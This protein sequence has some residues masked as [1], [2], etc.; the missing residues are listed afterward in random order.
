MVGGPA[1]VKGLAC[2]NL[3]FNW[4]SG[5]GNATLIDI[6]LQVEAGELIT[7]V[8]PSGSGKSTLLH[9]MAG[10]EQPQIGR[11]TLDGQPLLEPSPRIAIVYQEARLFP[12]L[13][14]RRNV[15]FGLR[16]AGMGKADRQKISSRLLGEVGLSRWSNSKP[17]ELSGGMKQ[18]IAL[19]RALAAQPD[20][21]LMDEPFAALDYQTRALMGKFVLDV[22]QSFN[23]TIVFVT[24]SIDEA[25]LLA[26]RIIV[27]SAH[28]GKILE[29]IKVDL[30]RPRNSTDAQFNDYRVH[31]MNHLEKEVTRTFNLDASLSEG[32]C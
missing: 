17:H 1:E 12:W 15:E 5:L 14:V 10:L 13:N 29:E 27:L 28:P 8:G 31:L 16:V 21:V 6:S 25:I 19:A 32:R 11:V 30:P 22:W 18:R 20:V 23:K 26:D 24:H 9:L 7:I 3:S 4:E 2:E